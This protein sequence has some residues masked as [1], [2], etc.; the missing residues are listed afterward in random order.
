MDRRGKKKRGAYYGFLENGQKGVFEVSFWWNSNFLADFFPRNYIFLTR[1]LVIFAVSKIL[2]TFFFLRVPCTRGNLKFFKII[3]SFYTFSIFII[4]SII[5][6][7]FF[8]VSYF[9]NVFL[10]HIHQ[11][12]SA[13]FSHSAYFSPRVSLFLFRLPSEFFLR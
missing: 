6:S 9:S 10:C 5:Q 11:S 8:T 2:F 3:S 7:Q 13:H 12:I 1:S 4:L